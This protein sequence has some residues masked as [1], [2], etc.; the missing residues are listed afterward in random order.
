VGELIPALPFQLR[1][2]PEPAD[3]RVTGDA[4]LEIT[5]GPRTDR[6]VDPRGRP[7]SSTAPSL[8]G[9]AAGDFTLSA[10][11]TVAFGSA[12]D[13]GALVVDVD[14]ETWAKLCLEYSPQGQPMV[15]SV[16]TRGVSDDC[17]SLPL[18]R[19]RVGLRVARMGGRAFAFHASTDGTT[20]RFVRHFA[21]DA[22]DTVQVG[23]LAQSPTGP[24]CTATFD[25]IRFERRR[26][27]DLRNGE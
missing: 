3:W 9:A 6:F 19:G 17:N 5:A 27:A 21:L 11:V 8:T 24:G 4:A 20:W 15:V 1:W 25:D 10:S 16:V 23:F 2:H 14:G 13:A 26:L 18:E 12:F 22:A 7:P